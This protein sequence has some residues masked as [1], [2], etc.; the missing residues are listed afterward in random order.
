MAKGSRSSDGPDVYTV[1]AVLA[2]VVLCFGIGLTIYQNNTVFGGGN[3]FS[4]QVSTR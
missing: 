3:P 4:S 1:L 2:F